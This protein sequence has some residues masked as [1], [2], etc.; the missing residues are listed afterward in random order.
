MWFPRPDCEAIRMEIHRL[1]D[2]QRQIDYR[3]FELEQ[4]RARILSNPFASAY[5]RMRVANID[6]E[7]SRLNYNRKEIDRHL[8]ALYEHARRI[9][10]L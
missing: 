6:A 8:T 7:I 2:T 10:C 4:L 9:G 1:R 5:D 3:I